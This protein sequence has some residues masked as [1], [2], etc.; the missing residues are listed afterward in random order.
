MTTAA[1]D[2]YLKGTLW[3]ARCHTRG[4][5]SRLGFTQAT[6]AHGQ[7]YDYFYCSRRE[8]GICDLP[9]LPIE[10]IEDAVTRFWSTQRPPRP[11][12]HVHSPDPRLHT[13][14]A[15]E[16]R[17]ASRSLAKSSSWLRDQVSPTTPDVGLPAAAAVDLEN[18]NRPTRLSSAHDKPRADYLALPVRLKVPSTAYSTSLIETDESGSAVR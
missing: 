10:R 18:L 14:V 17:M 7:Q 5:R 13:S 1:H 4:L 9:H 16:L 3:C 8:G 2:H 12:P 11:A 15:A 6:G